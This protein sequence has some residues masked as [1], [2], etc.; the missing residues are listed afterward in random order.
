MLIPLLGTINLAHIK[1][2]GDLLYKLKNADINKCMSSLCQILTNNIPINKCLD[3]PQK[4][5]NPHKC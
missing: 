4:K 2:S 1:T 3:P 5:K